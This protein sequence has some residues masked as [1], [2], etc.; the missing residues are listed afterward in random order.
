[1]RSR[2]TSAAFCVSE[3]ALALLGLCA[4]L[5]L[6]CAPLAYAT[7]TSTLAMRAGFQPNA[8]GSPTTLSFSLR[9]TGA[10][11]Q[12]TPP[13]T[14]LE[15]QIPRGMGLATSTLGLANCTAPAL[16]DSGLA[17]CS[18]DARIGGGEAIMQI[19][20]G[21]GSVEED[22]TI[23]ALIG[24]PNHEHLELLF[25]A[26]GTT[27]VITK[28]VFPSAMLPDTGLFGERLATA[29]PL[30]EVFPSSQPASMVQFNTT[31]GPAGLH[32][33]ERKHGRLV[34]FV[35]RG[36]VEPRVCPRGGFPFRAQ[37]TFADGTHAAA[38]TAVPCPPR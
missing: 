34:S 17:G 33:V 12:V 2:C 26:A 18:P 29:L 3:R 38:T 9:V 37:F 16:E 30:I 23:A 32:Y 22:V 5:A 7:P 25:Y 8:L 1:M 11:G 14:A 27:P 6:A 15:I 31:I 10:P 36:M 20:V 13:V 21:T 19:P 4:A 35:P 24:P 28:Q